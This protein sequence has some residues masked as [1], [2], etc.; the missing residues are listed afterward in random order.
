[1]ISTVSVSQLSTSPPPWWSWACRSSLR[2]WF[3]ST[4]TTTPT[5]DTCHDGSVLPLSA[6]LLR[7]R[8][9]I[10]SNA[11]CLRPGCD[12][13]GWGD[14]SFFLKVLRKGLFFLNE[15]GLYFL[16]TIGNKVSLQYCLD[17]IIS[18]V[19]PFIFILCKESIFAVF[20]FFQ[21][22]CNS[23]THAV[24]QCLGPI[25]F[26]LGL[27]SGPKISIFFNFFFVPRAT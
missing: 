24:T 13:V 22:L 4:I 16:L 3:C 5:A 8:W 11:N 10:Q 26:S 2:C 7:L 1:M 19:K 17:F 12:M 14:G 20:Y 27:R 23:P 21:D 6:F 15:K 9:S 18:R 25:P